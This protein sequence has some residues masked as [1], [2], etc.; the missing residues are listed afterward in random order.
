MSKS[1]HVDTTRGN[2][3]RWAKLPHCTVRTFSWMLKDTSP[4]T[5]IRGCPKA[6]NYIW[7]SQLLNSLKVTILHSKVVVSPFIHAALSFIF[8][9]LSLRQLVAVPRG[10]HQMHGWTCQHRRW[11]QCR[12]DVS[13]IPLRSTPLLRQKVIRAKYLFRSQS[14]CAR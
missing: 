9:R 7:R 4:T 1:S 5:N 14:S 11:P 8:R 6:T 10:L 3:R 12:H 13:I 2:A